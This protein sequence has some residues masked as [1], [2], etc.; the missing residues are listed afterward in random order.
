MSP[1]RDLWFDT[2]RL[3]SIRRTI[4]GDYDTVLAGQENALGTVWNNWQSDWLGEPVTTVD[5]PTNNS[6]TFPHLARM[7]LAAESG[8]SDVQNDRMDRG[9]RFELK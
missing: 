3:P 2:Q 8:G 1:S 5:Q 4:E 9:T 7:Q 6:P